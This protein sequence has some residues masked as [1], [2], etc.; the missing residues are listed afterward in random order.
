MSADDLIFQFDNLT[1]SDT[2]AHNNA[3]RQTQ[4]KSPFE[5][6]FKKNRHDAFSPQ[7]TEFNHVFDLA[8]IA[9]TLLPPKKTVTLETGL[10]LCYSNINYAVCQRYSNSSKAGLVVFGCRGYIQN[11]NKELKIMLYNNSQRNIYIN[12][13]EIIA[14]I[15]L[16][17]IIPN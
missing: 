7:K 12:R 13:G 1:V 15:V 2:N 14:S 8:S 5:K 9:D 17:N 11:E 3:A 16:E 6:Y 10:I 4:R